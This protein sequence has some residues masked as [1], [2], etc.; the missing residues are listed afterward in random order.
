MSDI[1]FE[2]EHYRGGL[3]TVVTVRAIPYDLLEFKFKRK[4]TTEEGKVIV[5]NEYTMFFEP[6]EF[7]NFFTPL[8]NELKVRFEMTQNLKDSDDFKANILNA[9]RAD[10][11]TV[12]FTKADGTERKMLCTLVESKI[13]ADKRPKS[14]TQSSSTVGSAVRVFDVD[15]GEWR[16][17]RFD[18]VKSFNGVDYV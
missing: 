18:A 11:S 14:E 13:P 3:H 17:F 8:V 7:K 2:A 9:L 12:V 16:S 5:D 4:M 15:K 10:V 6:E 1:N